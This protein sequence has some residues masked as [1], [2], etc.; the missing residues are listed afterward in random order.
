MKKSMYKGSVIAVKSKFEKKL[1]ELA[2]YQMLDTKYCK[3]MLVTII[4][5]KFG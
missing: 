4:Y 1:Y 2:R 5:K 3:G